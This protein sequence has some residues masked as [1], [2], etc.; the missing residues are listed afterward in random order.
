VY[1]RNPNN[2]HTEFWELEIGQEMVIDEQYLSNK[3]K[4]FLN[5]LG[6][7]FQ[8]KVVGVFHRTLSGSNYLRTYEVVPGER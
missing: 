3:P 7:V 6:G 2:G 5:T 1:F 8:A 4:T